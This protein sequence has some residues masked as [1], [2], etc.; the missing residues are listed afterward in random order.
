M[1]E[2]EARSKLVMFM[3]TNKVYKVEIKNIIKELLDM[4][5]IWPRSSLFVY[6][7]VLVKKKDMMMRMCI[8]YML[9]NKKTINNRYPIIRVDDLIDELH[10]A[11]HFSKI[12][13]ISSY[14]QIKTNKE[15]VH[16]ISFRYHYG[17]FKFLVIPFG[18]TNAL[19]TFQLIMNQVSGGSYGSLY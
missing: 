4:G 6:S 19:I 9:L 10:R 15:D 7:M 17:H 2:L 18:L 11:K 8:D 12:N 14:H 1:V 13:L 5:F 3:P 16:K